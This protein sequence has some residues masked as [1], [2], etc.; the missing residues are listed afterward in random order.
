MYRKIIR[1]E[2]EVR[3]KIHNDYYIE[4]DIKSQLWKKKEKEREVIHNWCNRHLKFVYE[5]S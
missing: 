2:R 1:E 5:E 4:T 3:R